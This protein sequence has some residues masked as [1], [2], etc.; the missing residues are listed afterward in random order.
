MAL[1]KITN[2]SILDDTIVNDDINNVSAAKVTAGTLATA[3]GGT[4]TTSTTF[5]N[6]ASNVTGNLPVANLN[7]GTSASSSTFWRG[8]ATW[9]AA[10][11]DTPYF[12]ASLNVDQG[13]ANATDTKIQMNREV[14]DSGTTYDPDT[15]YRFTPGVAGKY[16]FRARI[17]PETAC[18][19]G[20]DVY[21]TVWK[22]GAA[23]GI[24]PLY[25]SFA[26]YESIVAYEG[27]LDSNTT[28]YF[29]LYM[30]QSTGGTFG[31]YESGSSALCYWMG[32]RIA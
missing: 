2:L 9:A 32:W 28:D 15:N 19:S 14:L 23:A 31:L 11:Q 5:T 1:S 17:T 6:L 22:N 8:D 29:E 30:Y 4:G 21:C 18:G 20:A 3:R 27:I 26:A 16:F 13:V 7:S 12:L 25:R 10:A 24:N